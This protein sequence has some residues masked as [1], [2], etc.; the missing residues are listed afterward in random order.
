MDSA[1]LF[2]KGISFPPRVGADG[3]MVWSQGEE[4]V[5]E[6]IRIILMTEQ[7]ERI[8]LPEFGGGLERYLFEPN[9]VATRQLIQDRIKKALARWEPRIAVESVVAE[10]DPDD[11]QA[12]I[13]S[14]TYRLVATQVSEKMTL[15]VKLS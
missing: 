2:G 13:V 3:R 7:K 14:I 1:H 9:T 15:G 10:P 4:N 12:A 6:S 11:P 5:R 8:M